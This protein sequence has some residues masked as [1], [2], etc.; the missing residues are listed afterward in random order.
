MSFSDY[1]KKGFFI[2]F[3]PP[4]IETSYEETRCINTAC[5]NNKKEVKDDFKFCPICGSK[6]DWVDV[7]DVELDSF[8]N[9]SDI[10]I[11]IGNDEILCDWF[12]SPE[13]VSDIIDE[14]WCEY[15]PEKD[16]EII[17]CNRD[18]HSE[19]PSDREKFMNHPAT[20]FLLDQLKNNYEI[21]Y[22]LVSYSA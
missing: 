17:L 7:V 11:P 3:S 19:L 18:F 4:K 22:G 8:S 10:T 5:K 6:I 12:Y 14:H 2:V 16:A 21:K 1:N 13:Y 9:Y 15:K 20:K